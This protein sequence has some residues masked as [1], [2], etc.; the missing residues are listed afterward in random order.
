VALARYA[1]RDPDPADA[2]CA[3]ERVD[4]AL[5]AAEQIVADGGEPANLA[6]GLAV[7]AAAVAATE[8]LQA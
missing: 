6:I 4:A 1:C 5:A 3:L 8:P 7:A 2:G